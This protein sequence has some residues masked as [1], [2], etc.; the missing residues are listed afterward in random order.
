[1]KANYHTHTQRCKHACGSDEDY[2]LSAI[3]AGYE[4]LG[5]S[6]HTPWKYASDYQPTMRM[7]L[8]EFAGY[9]Q[10]ILALKEK[11]KDQISIKLGVEA[12]YFEA[13]MPWLKEFVKEQELDYVL[14]GNHFYQSD[15]TRYYYG[16]DIQDMEGMERYVNDAIKGMETGLYAYLAHPDLFMRSLREWNEVAEYGARTICAKAKE[17]DMI[18]EYNIAGKMVSERLGR[19]Q[20]PHHRFWEIA[21]E[22]GCKAIVG[23][24]AHDNKD[25][26]KNEYYDNARAYL[27]GLGL[28]VVDTIDFLK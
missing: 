13:Y 28:T 22:T 23:M 16:R 19:E 10:S 25:L 9:K 5:F 18:L 11:Y 12:E 4:E 26:E 8:S 15:E 17:L 2:V 21:A 6:D 3:K 14:F 7:A 24:D 27:K 1:M 20:Y